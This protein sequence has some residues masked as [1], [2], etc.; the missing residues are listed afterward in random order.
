MSRMVSPRGRNRSRPFYRVAY[1]PHA[2]SPSLVRAVQRH[3]EGGQQAIER[4]IARS[5]PVAIIAWAYSGLAFEHARKLAQ[6]GEA[7]FTGNFR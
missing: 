2:H 5:L 1:Q 3:V 4:G 7:A 6:A